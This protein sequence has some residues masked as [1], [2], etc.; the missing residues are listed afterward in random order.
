LS[1]LRRSYEVHLNFLM[2][3]AALVLFIACAN[4]GNL[5]LARAGARR[6]EIAARL[7]LGASRGRLI[8]QMLTES[9]LLSVCGAALGLLVAQWG[10]RIL[11]GMIGTGSDPLS[12]EMNPDWR[13]LSFMTAVA[14]AATLAFGLWPALRSTRVDLAPSLKESASSSSRDRSYAS[15]LFTFVQVS[16]SVVLLCAAGIFLRSLGNLRGIDLGI[17]AERLIQMDLDLN[18]AGYTPEASGPMVQRLLD[19]IRALPGVES[20]TFSRR[21][22]FI[23]GDSNSGF[24]APGFIPANSR[25]G[26]AF[27]DVVGDRY[28][29]TL[30]IRLLAGRVLG[31]RDSQSAVRV[32]VVN[33]ALARFFFPNGN[34]LGAKVALKGPGRSSAG[35]REI[36]GII[37]DARDHLVRQPARRRYYIPA[38]QY[39]GNLGSVSFLVRGPAYVIPQLRKAVRAADPNIPIS[40]L[41]AAT[42]LLDRQ[43]AAERIL[44][45]LAGYFGALALLVAAVGL[46][47]SLSYQVLR[48]TKE[49]GIR[50]ALGARKAHILW[51]ASAESLGLVIAGILIG[52]AASI[53]LSRWIESL[54]YD[55]KPIDP[56]SMSGAVAV[57]ALAAIPAVLIPAFRATRLDPARTL[58]ED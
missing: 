2:I 34:A 55:L 24:G 29:E 40:R 53:G 46:Y 50:V 44:A 39:D 42:D 23:T 3:A 27:Y 49:I 54:L 14:I 11:L 7:S 33:E 18:T 30:D 19:R 4:L 1:A 57:L 52:V 51:S 6:R 22:V 36:V 20:A 13:L 35:D 37:R 32:I 56:G 17:R 8:R 38:A 47:G 43:F 31:P 9:A 15:R 25:D 5:L 12:L 45:T 48:R 26:L 41:S 58:R 21:G 16:L 10:V 28:F